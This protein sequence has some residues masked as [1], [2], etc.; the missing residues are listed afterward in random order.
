MRT[1]RVRL[2]DIEMI[3]ASVVGTVK[4]GIWVR[5]TQHVRTTDGKVIGLAQ[6]WR[7]VGTFGVVD[8]RVP[9]NDDAGTV[10]ADRGFG[11]VIGWDLTA[12]GRAAHG[13]TS[14]TPGSRST[15]PRTPLRS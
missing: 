2:V 6:I 8:F 9:V 5:L 4:G 3:P 7:D 1:L 15:S 14:P 13:S 10:E 11:V 12:R